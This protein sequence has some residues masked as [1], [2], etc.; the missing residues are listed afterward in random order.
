MKKQ[1]PD[2]NN[3]SSMKFLLQIGATVLATTLLTGFANYVAI[4]SRIAVLETKMESVQ[5]QV[6]KLV[7]KHTIER[8]SN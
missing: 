4:S 6:T 3:G 7:D 5:S 1:A 2:T 8:D